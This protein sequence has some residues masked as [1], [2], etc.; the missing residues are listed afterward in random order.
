MAIRMMQ[1][2]TIDCDACKKPMGKMRTSR[3]VLEI[4]EQEL[5]Y[6]EVRCNECAEKDIPEDLR[7][8]K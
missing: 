7:A 1:K 6:T 2:V 3:Q 4:F 5:K 8:D